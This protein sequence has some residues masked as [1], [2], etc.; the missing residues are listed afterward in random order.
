MFDLRQCGLMGR[1]G[2]QYRRRKF[3]DLYAEA[4]H[5]SIEFPELG[6]GRLFSIPFVVNV[7]AIL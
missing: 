5:Q 6:Y 3:P 2:L 4:F 7:Y 1:C